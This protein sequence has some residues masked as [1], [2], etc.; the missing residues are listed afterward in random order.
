MIRRTGFPT[1][2]I[3]VLHGTR[4]IFDRP[5]LST[6][7]VGVWSKHVPRR[8]QVQSFSQVS[9]LT[10]SQFGS[11]SPIAMVAQPVRSLPTIFAPPLHQTGST[12]TRYLTDFI[13]RIPLPIQTHG[14]VT[15]A[16]GS[17]FLVPKGVLQFFV[18]RFSRLQSFSWHTSIVRLCSIFSIRCDCPDSQPSISPTPLPSLRP[19]EQRLSALQK[20]KDATHTTASFLTGKFCGPDV[21]FQMLVE[22]T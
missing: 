3:P 14:L 16:S 1:D 13:D 7:C 2:P 20:I 6:R 17:I 9:Q 11:I 22:T 15:D 18:L 19:I 21:A 5:M 12:A 8:V 10:R 4:Q